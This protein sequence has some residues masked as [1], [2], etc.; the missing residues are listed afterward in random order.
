[1]KGVDRI[2]G[3]PEFFYFQHDGVVFPV[4]VVNVSRFYP[5][6][7]DQTLCVALYDY[8]GHGFGISSLQLFQQE[9]SSVLGIE[10][11]GMPILRGFPIEGMSG[12][13]IEAIGRRWWDEDNRANF[14]LGIMAVHP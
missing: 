2:I 6:V 9:G 3:E 11:H 7:V 12:S 5:D 4:L 14:G 10:L 1:M 13:M 8:P